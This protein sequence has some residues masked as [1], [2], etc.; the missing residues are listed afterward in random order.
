MGHE[1]FFRCLNI[2]TKFRVTLFFLSQHPKFNRDE[3][4]AL[5]GVKKSE[6]DP[7]VF[8]FYVYLRTHPLITRHAIANNAQ[9]KMG[10]GAIMLT[11]FRGAKS[12]D[13][14]RIQ[15]IYIRLLRCCIAKGS[16]VKI[17]PDGPSKVGSC[18]FCFIHYSSPVLIKEVL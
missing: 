16:S 12:I 7:S 15:H 13:M 9:K 6:T 3:A 11:G 17:L 14:V 8:N 4:V 2:F 18:K 10:G 5:S 1:F